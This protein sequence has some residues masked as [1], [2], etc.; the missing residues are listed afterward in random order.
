[1]KFTVEQECVQL[2]LCRRW[3]DGENDSCHSESRNDSFSAHCSNIMPAVH[4]RRGNAGQ[5]ESVDGN[6]RLNLGSSRVASV[7]MSHL[8]K[9]SLFLAVCEHESK[10]RITLDPLV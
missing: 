9:V 6:T 1:M 2:F 4:S 7:L 10:D 8:V 5:G 3:E